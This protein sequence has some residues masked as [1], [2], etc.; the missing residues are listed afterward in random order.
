MRHAARRR[1]G[2]RP[3][4]QRNTS[5]LPSMRRL[6]R[7]RARR[8]STSRV[9]SSPCT[10]FTLRSSPC[11]MSWLDAAR[12]VGGVGKSRAMRAG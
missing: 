11:F 3:G 8:L 7:H 12:A 5:V 10:T 4:W 6:V 2:D 9:R 1:A